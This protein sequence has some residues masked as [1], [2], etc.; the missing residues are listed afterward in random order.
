[1]QLMPATSKSLGVTDPYDPE[2]NIE[3]GAKYLGKLLKQ[4]D[5]DTEKALW[6]YNAGPG[7]VAKGRKPSETQAY[8][9]NVMGIYNKLKANRPAQTA[10]QSR[11][12]Q[13]MPMYFNPTNGKFITRNGFDRLM[14]ARGM[15][16][17]ELHQA[18]KAEGYK[19]NES[20]I[21]AYR[22]PDNSAQTVQGAVPPVTSS[23]ISTS[24]ELPALSSDIDW[25][26]SYQIMNYGQALSAPTILD[27]INHATKADERAGIAN[28]NG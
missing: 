24:V 19:P 6:A 2:Q 21:N 7:N 1:M 27:T 18:L 3:G 14:K 22:Q 5:G 11:T 25:R 12:V 28:L 26:P 9:K 17:E 13:E 20:I 10:G 16:E 15:S 8:I 4:Y 23:D